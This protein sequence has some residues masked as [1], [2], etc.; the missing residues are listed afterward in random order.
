MYAGGE[1]YKP[2]CGCDNITYRNECAAIHWG[3]LSTWTPETVCG[4]FDFDFRPTALSY[5]ATDNYPARFQAFIKNPNH[6]N[7][8]IALYIYDDFGKLWYSWNSATGND[9]LFPLEAKE[10]PL[11]TL[12]QGIYIMIVVVNNEKQTLKF[13]KL[14]N[15]D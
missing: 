12:K 13:S 15:D 7:I 3:G 5:Q 11:Q 10:L 8:G 6:V 4:N 14:T 1:E 9:G 2:V